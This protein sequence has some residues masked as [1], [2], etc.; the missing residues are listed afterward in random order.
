MKGC[1]GRFLGKILYIFANWM[2]GVSLSG[3][4]RI[5][6]ELSKRWASALEIVFLVSCEG[7]EICR[8]EG[9]EGFSSRIWSSGRFNKYGYYIDYLYRSL[10]SFIN[11]LRLDIRDTHCVYSS[12]D[13]W[14]DVIP[15]LIL[16]IRKKKIVWIAGFFLF[17]VPPWH[18]ESPYKRNKWFLGLCYWLSQRPAY[19]IVKS[20]A[21]MVFVTSDPDVGYF[22][23]RKRNRK[24][25][26]VIRGGVDTRPA[27]AYLKSITLVPFE[28][29]KF[30]SCFVGR[31]HYQKGVLDLVDIWSFVCRKLPK[32]KLAM[33]GDGPLV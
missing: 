12:S 11:A 1:E 4:D 18:K 20:F 32:A 17:I 33:I 7:W 3:G 26:V 22:L 31:F 19:W 13:F 5:F 15:A 6:I 10:N 24:K 9:L 30:D 23:T 25:I 14:P 27:Q 2:Q 8:R 21:D 28:Q 29:K 16:K